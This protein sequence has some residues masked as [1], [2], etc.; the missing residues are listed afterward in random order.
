MAADETHNKCKG[1]HQGL[2][3]FHGENRFVMVSIV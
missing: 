3:F 1:K 2:D